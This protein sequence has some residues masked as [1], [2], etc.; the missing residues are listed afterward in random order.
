MSKQYENRLIRVFDY[1]SANLDGDLSLDALAEVAAMSRFHWH[2]VFRA[3]TGETQ[4]DAVRRLRLTRA[5]HW[6]VETDWPIG[7]IL[8][9]SGFA[10]ERSFIR[11]F[12]AL[13]GLTPAAFRQRGALPPPPTLPAKGQT[14]MYPVDIL[15]QPA[16]R[17]AAVSHR[18]PY[19][20]IGAAFDKISAILAARGEGG[21]GRTM[22][23]IFYDDPSQTPETEL[24]SHA[25]VEVEPD[26]PIDAPM[27]EVRL[28][29]GRHAVMQ[30]TG[31]YSGLSA[32]YDQLYC[33][34]L[35][36]S[37]EEPADSPVFEVYRNTPM[38][39]EPDKLRTDL[40]LPLK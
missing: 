37:G 11:A 28:P 21:K 20:E 10:N 18:G 8:R 36:G 27:E 7:E 31:P 39:T 30:Y 40:M 19:L 35:P 33:D 32:A 24:R 38:D 5:A 4:A 3:M 17:L 14:T 1:M 29:A 22:A 34:W 16:R 26:F 2:R 9:R 12:T 6:L 23:G 13:H 15:D 25:A